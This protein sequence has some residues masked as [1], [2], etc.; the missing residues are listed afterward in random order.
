MKR[1]FMPTFKA[2]VWAGVLDRP[3]PE[4]AGYWSNFKGSLIASWEG[5]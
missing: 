1:I 4:T 2:W 5:A 3:F